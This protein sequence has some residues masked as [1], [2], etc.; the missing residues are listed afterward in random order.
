MEV[1]MEK[2]QTLFKSTN[3]HQGESDVMGVKKFGGEIGHYR[4]ALSV[5]NQNLDNRGGG[6]KR[7]GDQPQPCV[8]SKRAL[9]QKLAAEIAN[10]KQCCQEDVRKSND[11]FGVW[12]DDN[13]DDNEDE[14]EDEN[15]PVPMFLETSDTMMDQRDHDMEEVE[16]EDIF[17]ESV[18]DIDVCDQGNHLA[19]V[20]YV[21]DLYANY[22]K[23]ENCSMVPPDY[24]TQQCDLNEKMRAILIDWLIEVHH[25]FDLQPETLF[26]TVNLIDRFL[27]KQSVIRKNLQLVG[28]VAMLLA[29][30][31]EE[32]S[33]PIIDD[34]IFISDKA[35][36]KKQILEMEK[37]MVN[38]LEFNM[39]LPTAY[40]FMKRFLKAAQSESKLDQISFFLIELCLVEYEMLKFPPSLLA[41][42]AVYTGQCSL[43]GLKQWSKTC[44]WYTNYSEDQL[45]E[46]SRMIV[47]YHQKAALGRLTGVYRKY[48]SSKFGYAAKC[49]PGKFLVE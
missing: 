2:N 46:C 32:V 8:A 44:E 37:L 23:M 4:R 35:Y 41:A 48:N 39:S 45:Q 29:C 19:V 20:E 22:R 34:L 40:V 11:G 7:P 27:A 9:S 33:V 12:E 43:Y 31:Y 13:E 15:E 25:K 10:K 16:M 5:I 42:A 3:T 30:K 21:E 28:L 18:I 26:L 24:M 17:E 47:G 14:D 49:E 6:V 36:S 38:T 1:S